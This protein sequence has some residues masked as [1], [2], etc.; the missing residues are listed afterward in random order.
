MRRQLLT[1]FYQQGLT[2]QYLTL[3]AIVITMVAMWGVMDHTLL[4]IWCAWLVCVV[5]T[6]SFYMKRFLNDI[7]AVSNLSPWEVGGLI[8]TAL[9]GLS[10]G[11]L[12]LTYESSWPVFYQVFLLVLLGSLTGVSTRG[13]TRRGHPRRPRR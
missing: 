3:A 2:T 12:G 6:R 5:I 13:A 11:V 7:D 9:G 8:G 4:L 10:W 1:L